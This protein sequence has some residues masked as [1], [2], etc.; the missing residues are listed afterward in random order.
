[1]PRVAIQNRLAAGVADISA[2]LSSVQQTIEGFG[3][4]DVFRDA[5]PLSDALA[6]TFFSTTAGIGL[7][8]LRTGI[9]S[10]GTSMS[11]YSNYVKAAARGAKIIAST[12]SAAAGQKDSGSEF[13]GHL[14][15]GSY[16][17]WAGTLAAFQGLVQ[18]N[19]S[20]NLYALEVQNEPDMGS[21]NRSMP[22]TTAEMTNFVKV[23]GPLVAALTPRPL[24]VLPATSNW[25]TAASYVTAV[26]ADGTAAPYLDRAVAHQY[27]GTPAVI[28]AGTATWQTEMAS[29]DAFDASITN[30]LVVAGWIHAALTS[31]NVSMWCYWWM[32]SNNTDNE[33]LIGNGTSSGADTTLTKRLYALGNWSKFVRPGYVRVDTT[34]A[35]SGV[36]LTA[37]TSSDGHVVIVAINVNG[38]DVIANIGVSGLNMPSMTPWV[39]DAT[40]DL[41]AQAPVY[42]RGNVATVTLPA[43]SVTSLVGVGT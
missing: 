29:F 25:D 33:G 5:T 27:S 42:A 34:G 21:P 37:F 38:S 13:G 14:L 32:I 10:D 6:D 36:S 31:A 30:A 40:R 43:S 24:L 11:F 18:T 41:V 1:M 28:H 12:W 7:S 15:S 2:T 4:A 16:S 19:A 17:A 8:I 39:T 26:L 23:L 20:V 22:Y 35:M 9:W 3:T